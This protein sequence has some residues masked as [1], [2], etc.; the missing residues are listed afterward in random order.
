MALA[1]GACD[2]E[3]D[4]CTPGY[5]TCDCEAEARCLEGLQCLSNRCVDPNASP[6]T[7]DDS[8]T[9]QSGALAES[10]EDFDNVSAC[11]ALLD[12]LECAPPA[13]V[14]LID[15]ASFGSSPCDISDY[16]NCLEDNAT[17]NGDQLDASGWT[18]CADLAVCS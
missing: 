2:G 1:L 14:A 15:C 7:T 16:L 12:S 13:G 17:C 5:E 3:Q 8:D 4:G 10:G 11:E 18:E 9:A 6:D